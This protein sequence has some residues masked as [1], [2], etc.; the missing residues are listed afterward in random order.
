MCFA[1]LTVPH[2]HQG[3]SAF[4]KILAERIRRALLRVENPD[5]RTLS[6]AKSQVFEQVYDKFVMLLI[7]ERTTGYLE[8]LDFF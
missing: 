2:K 4:F 1:L 8:R 3:R 7:E 6:F 5:G